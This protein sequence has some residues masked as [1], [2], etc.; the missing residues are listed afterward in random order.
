MQVNHDLDDRFPNLKI[1]PPLFYD[2]PI[3]IRFELG[4]PDED[5]RERYM[6]RVY[7]R[8]LSLFKALHSTHDE[9]WMI[10]NV[11]HREENL[12]RRR[13]VKIF[14]HYVKSKEVLYRLQHQVIPWVFE[15]LDEYSEGLQTHRYTLRCKVSDVKYVHLVKALCNRD[16]AINPKIEHDLFFVNLSRDT[17]FHIYDDRGCDVIAS[18]KESIRPLYETYSEWILPYDKEAIDR[19]FQERG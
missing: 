12:W 19:V 6:E 15:D 11:H 17:I 1:R 9:M 5:N 18:T 2:W 16:M 10:A 3:G 8:A 4:D 7:F 13:R 14:Q